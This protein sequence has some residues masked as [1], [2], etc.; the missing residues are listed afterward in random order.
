MAVPV[1]WQ[2]LDVRALSQTREVL[3]YQDGGL[4]PVLAAASDG[5]IVAVLRG[6]AGHVGLDG[7]IEVIRSLDA[8]RTWTPPN[9]IADSDR[10]DRNPACGVSRGG[11]LVLAYHRQGSYDEEGNY[12]PNRASGNRPVEVLITRSLDAGLTWEAPVPLGVNLLS[13]ASPYGKIPALDDG[14][15]LLP[16]YDSLHPAL[17][18]AKKG[19]MRPEGSCSYLVRSRDDGKTW[20]D[21]SL[22]A[23]DK[24][25][26]A[27]LILPDGDLLAVLRGSD[28]DQALWSVRSADGGRSWSEP[29]QITG[30]YQHPADL[31][32][33]ANGDVLLTYG[34]RN[35]PY[36]I[37]G[38]LSRDGGRT[39]LDLLLVFS[40]HLYGS[41]VESPR[42]TDLGYP[43]SAVRQGH[44]VTMYYYNPSLNLPAQWRERAGESRYLARDYRAVAVT[45][46]EEELVSAVAR[47]GAG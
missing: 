24:D 35:P 19:Q 28:T 14:T 10:D 5:A 25:E 33:L 6:G 21:P 41:N 20:G 15:L 3:A 11:T 31:V 45:W 46:D 30:R 36:R 47:A 22:I 26:T 34:N 12:R 44:G 38:R 42:P 7:R 32:L 27:L 2:L 4:F 8:G 23:F 29:V 39:W 13:T 43:S 18:G 1:S 40:G 37:E 9:V 17:V 16:L